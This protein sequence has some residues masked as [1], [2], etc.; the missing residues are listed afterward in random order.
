M[1][2]RKHSDMKQIQMNSRRT[3]CIEITRA[4]AMVALTAACIAAPAHAQLIG[5]SRNASSE[6]Y[7][8]NQTFDGQS[9]FRD[10]NSWVVTKEFADTFGMPPSAVDSELK[11][12]EAAAFRIEDSGRPLCGMGGKAENCKPSYRDRKSVV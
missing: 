9:Y 1:T 12:I 3:L 5:S 2:A 4:G 6:R 8:I 7:E 10:N 11:G